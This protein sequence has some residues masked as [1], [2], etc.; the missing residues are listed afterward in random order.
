MDK[1]K[2]LEV[3]DIVISDNG[4]N[5]LTILLVTDVSKNRFKTRCSHIYG[6]EYGSTFDRRSG[7]K[8][9]TVTRPD[10]RAYPYSEFLYRRAAAQRREIEH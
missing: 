10:V 8:I 5:G 6:T 9:G 3:G 2:H 7:L 1:F 4:G